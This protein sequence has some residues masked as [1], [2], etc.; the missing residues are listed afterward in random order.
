VATNRSGSIKIRGLKE[1]RAEL[2]ELENAKEFETEL[3]DVHHRIAL[4]IEAKA[5]PKLARI[6]GGMG[7]AAAGTLSARRSVTGAQVSLGGGDVPWAL[8][9]EFGAKQN[10]RRI[11]KNTRKYRGVDLNVGKRR[12]REGGRAT[13]VRDDE[14]L[15][16]VLGRIRSQTIDFSRKNTAKRF[17]GMGAFGVDA[18]TYSTGRR[19]GQNIVIRGWNQFLPW[20]GIGEGAGYAIF[21]T[22][23]DSQDEIARMYEEEVGRI[24]ARAFPD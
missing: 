18:A 24:T 1:L 4:M 9:V 10:L 20:R 5:S 23:R 15:D 22:I 16:Q 14:D 13:I 17:R 7:S 3:K 2:K 19:A 8:G 12:I 6:K 21:P 11:V